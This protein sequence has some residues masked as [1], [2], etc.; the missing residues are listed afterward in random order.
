MKGS[1]TT[2]F[3]SGSLRTNDV[4]GGDESLILPRIAERIAGEGDG[5]ERYLAS[6]AIFLKLRRGG[7]GNTNGRVF[8]WPMQTIEISTKINGGI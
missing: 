6:S 8:S 7:G 4:S 3:R 1:P 5:E 2:T